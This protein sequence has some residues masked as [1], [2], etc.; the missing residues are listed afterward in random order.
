ME[1]RSKLQVAAVFPAFLAMGFGDAI[2]PFV[3]LVREHYQTCNFMATLIPSTSLLIFLLL[4]IPMGIYQN[5]KENKHVMVIG[6]FIA[7]LGLLLPILRDLKANEP[8]S[9]PYSL[10]LLTVLLLVAILYFLYLSFVV[11]GRL[12]IKPAT[13]S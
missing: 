4:S 6:L 3:G 12:K 8:D 13:R 7:L 10:S 1:K 9:F 5:K 2:G 11:P